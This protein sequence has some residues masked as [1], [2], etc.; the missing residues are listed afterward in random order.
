MK[1]T[2]EYLEDVNAVLKNIPE[3][4]ELRGKGILITGA[5][6]LIC[7]A[8]ADLLFSLNIEQDYGMTIYL[9]GRDED[10]MAKRFGQRVDKKDYVFVQY[11]AAKGGLDVKGAAIDYIIHGASNADPK[12]IMA[13]PVETMLANIQGISAILDSIDKDKLSR[14]LYVSSSEVY[15]VNEKFEPY[16]ENQFGYVDILNPRSSYPSS[17]RAAE[18]LL[19][20]Y[21]EEYGIDVVMVRPGYIYG[22]TVK[23]S[24]SRAS[25]D[26]SFKAVRGQE[27]VMKSKGEQLRSYCHV[28]D[29]AS[30]M[31]AVLIKGENKEAYNISAPISIVT[32]R[33]MAEAFAEAGGVKITFDLPTEAETKS[34]NKVPCSALNSDKLEALGWKAE[35]DMKRGA[36]RTVLEMKQ[37]F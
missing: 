11:D 30:A 17:K 27:I 28:L 21:A 4:E 25:A 19:V 1:Y 35:F 33:E 23:T 24:D 2:N 29:C 8:V 9:A 7:S 26:F 14:F 12:R 18:T 31:L 22:P 5:T 36:E 3:L 16:T 13:E 37:I 20:A 32:I 10:R 15:G 34:Y 6:G